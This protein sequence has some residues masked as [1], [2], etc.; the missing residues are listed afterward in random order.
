MPTQFERVVAF[1]ERHHDFCSAYHNHKEAM[2]YAGFTLYAGVAGAAILSTGWPPKW[3]VHT[4]CLAFLAATGLWVLVLSFL[5]FQLLR[6]RWAAV[7]RA[8]CERLLARWLI[9]L[10]TNEELTTL[11]APVERDLAMWISIVD[12]VVPLRAAVRSIKTDQ[13][14]YPISLVREWLSREAAGTE[15]IVHERI[16]VIAAWVLYLVLV[17][18]I[19]VA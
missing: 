12:Y 16:L 11:P 17:L 18:R 9:Q 2:A 7:R 1:V 15:A 5:K 8:G 10:P 19:F 3:G 4:S 6:R 13:T 14:V